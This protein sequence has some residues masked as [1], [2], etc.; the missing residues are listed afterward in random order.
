[1]SDDDFLK[2]FRKV[3]P[4]DFDQKLFAHLK[5]I[6][7]EQDMLT[8]IVPRDTRPLLR[9]VAM[10]AFVFSMVALFLILKP[11]PDQTVSRLVQAPTITPTP[12]NPCQPYI[13]KGG[14]TLT[15]I[16]LSY[17]VSIN[18]LTEVNGLALDAV[19]Q[20]GDEL[21]IPGTPC[22]PNGETAPVE[23]FCP[24]DFR[25]VVIARQNIRSG[26]L[27]TPELLQLTC[28]ALD[29][30]RYQDVLDNIS[31]AVTLI[32]FDNY[33][34]LFD[35]IEDALGFELSAE[36][37]QWSPILKTQV[38]RRIETSDQGLRVESGIIGISGDPDTEIFY[39][40]TLKQGAFYD[41]Q[42]GDEVAIE[43]AYLDPAEVEDCLEGAL[44]DSCPARLQES[45]TQERIVGTIVGINTYYPGSLA[46]KVEK[47]DLAR[48]QWIAAVNMP[49]NIYV[50]RPAAP[51]LMIE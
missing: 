17:E 9:L 31:D 21:L 37:R 18:E 49:F 50:I 14:E 29:D 24:A 28:W 43:V 2:R 30:N 20:R 1:M 27:L 13:V 45:V 10:A 41:F 33:E 22:D 3:P 8:T 23:P 5:N 19:L 42:L 39:D 46:L 47:G 38:L 15:S 7:K 36:V 4:P 44:A 34:V 32:G 26:T 40:L 51:R 25:P 11:A 6:D 48:L 12:A 16:A 35:S